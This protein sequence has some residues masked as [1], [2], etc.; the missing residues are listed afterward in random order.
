MNKTWRGATDVI[1]PLRFLFIIMRSW[2]KLQSIRTNNIIYICK[3]KVKQDA[4]FTQSM[5]Q[6]NAMVTC[7][8]VHCLTSASFYA[9]CI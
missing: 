2:C 5:Q 4:S 9:S 6:S 3:V 7:V 8:R 1:A